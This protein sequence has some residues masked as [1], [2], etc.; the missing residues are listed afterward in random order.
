MEGSEE[1][2]MEI[3][4]EILQSDDMPEEARENEKLKSFC[5]LWQGQIM[6]GHKGRESSKNKMSEKDEKW[7]QL[8]Q[9]CKAVDVVF[10]NALDDFDR[11]PQIN[12]QP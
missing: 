2:L 1:Y 4:G 6:F 12:R 7:L 10:Y 8:Q 9:C 3:C 11:T 5:D